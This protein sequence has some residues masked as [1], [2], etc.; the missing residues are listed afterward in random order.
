MSVLSA[1]ALVLLTLVGY[2]SGVALA[3]RERPFLPRMADLLLVAMLWAVAFWLRGQINHWLMIAIGLILGLVLGYGATTVRL[4]R[5]ESRY[6]IPQ[7]E[8]PEHARE[9]DETAGAEN[10]FKRLW[11]RWNEFTAVMGNVQARLIMGFFYF[12][13]V[14]PFGLIM[15]AAGDP[16]RI[17]EAPGGGG[18]TPKQATDTTV[19]AA[20]EQG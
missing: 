9:K 2:S 10:R 8:L 5:G 16:L 3:S 4:G 17:K 1:I 12:I 6:A 7:S 15:R 20:R 11:R 18:W 19:E 14:T 13:F